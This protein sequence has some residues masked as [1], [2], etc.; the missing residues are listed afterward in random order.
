MALQCPPRV[1][2]PVSVEQPPA[3][4]PKS[5]CALE[6]LRSK[7]SQSFR[8]LTEKWICCEGSRPSFH[9]RPTVTAWLGTDG[10][11]RLPSV[12]ALSDGTIDY[13]WNGQGFSDR[14]EASPAKHE[15]DNVRWRIAIGDA[16]A[17]RPFEVHLEVYPFEPEVLGLT[18][19]AVVKRR[20][21]DLA[22]AELVILEFDEAIERVWRELATGPAIELFQVKMPE[23][24]NGIQIY[25]AI[26]G[27]TCAPGATFRYKRANRAIRE[28]AMAWS[29]PALGPGDVPEGPCPRE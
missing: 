6:R 15:I 11:E 1:T 3:R 12:A 14:L 10:S 4:S 2:A 28:I 26:E 9:I 16:A 27:T 29:D 22:T 24:P 20:L 19:I 7:S 8:S 5:Y 13:C 21:V 25:E 17:H 23:S 18:A